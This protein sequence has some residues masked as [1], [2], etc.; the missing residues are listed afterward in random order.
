MGIFAP[1]PKWVT[2]ITEFKLLGEKLYVS[3]VLYLYNDEFITY[4]IGSRPT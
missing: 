3:P 2:D 1:E 4:T